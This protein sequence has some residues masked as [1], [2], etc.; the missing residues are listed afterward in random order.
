MSKQKKSSM[1]IGGTI[2]LVIFI[3][4]VLIVIMAFLEVGPF[5][6]LKTELR[7]WAQDLQVQ[8]QQLMSNN[9]ASPSS[10]AAA[11]DV[12]PVPIA[13]IAQSQTISNWEYSLNGVQ[14][15]S[16]TVT[17]DMSIRNTSSQ[18]LPFGFSYQV[19]DESFTTVYKLCAQNSNKQV[20]WDIS[21]NGNGTGFY[22]RS[23]SPG[24][25]KT[26]QMKFTISHG[27]EKVYLCLS[28][29]GNVAN[30]LFYLGN[31]P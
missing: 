23:F 8:A 7:R 14:W 2:V 6:L 21:Q 30:K 12:S 20:F 24:E 26:G 22:N 13:T 29:G 1:P 9:Q 19:S 17:L 10:T 15:N 4:L 18:T 16:N 28:V 3:A 5:P 27:S 31:V 11:V 25:T